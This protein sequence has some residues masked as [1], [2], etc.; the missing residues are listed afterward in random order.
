MGTGVSPLRVGRCRRKVDIRKG[1]GGV[2]V[3]GCLVASLCDG[4]SGGNV[5]F[6]PPLHVEDDR[7][8]SRGFVEQ[9]RVLLGMAGAFLFMWR[10]WVICG[11]LVF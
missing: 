2:R 11:G 7:T 1:R 4:L 8:T 10:T 9:G 3:G 6:A 5:G